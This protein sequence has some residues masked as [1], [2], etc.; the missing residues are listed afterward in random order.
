MGNAVAS[1]T[2]RVG[3]ISALKAALSEAA[4]RY[5][6]ANPK[7]LQYHRDAT[8]V[9]PGGNTR[10]VPHYDP[11]PIAFDRA[12]GAILHDLDGHTYTD[13]LGEFSAGLY[14]HSHPAIM[15]AAAE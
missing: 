15:K 12:E 7:S 2:S 8:A 10:S 14:G 1:R 9:M 4:E 11:F 6:R 5:T 13:F 3:N